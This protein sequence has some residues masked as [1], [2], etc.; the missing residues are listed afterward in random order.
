MDACRSLAMRQVLGG[1]PVSS[2]AQNREPTG[3]ERMAPAAA[4]QPALPRS[5]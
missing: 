4:W 3:G 2:A 1:Q 5:L